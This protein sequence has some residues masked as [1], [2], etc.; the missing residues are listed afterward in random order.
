VGTAFPFLLH[1]LRVYHQLLQPYFLLHQPPGSI[2]GFLE[3]LAGQFFSPS[4]GLLVF[5]PVL[6][7]SFAGI[8]SSFPAPLADTTCILP[9]LCTLGLN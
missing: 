5:S 8:V 4:R 2:G 7:F 3:A 1:N 6:L 9:E